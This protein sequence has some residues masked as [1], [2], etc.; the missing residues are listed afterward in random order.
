MNA[1][2]ISA[3]R[4]NIE[5]IRCIPVFCY[6]FA[7]NETLDFFACHRSRR[8]ANGGRTGRGGAL[9][10]DVRH[11]SRRRRGPRAH[12]RGS[13]LHDCRACARRSRNRRDDLSDQP[14]HPRRAARHRRIRYRQNL[15]GNPANPTVG[16][17]HVS[18]ACAGFASSFRDNSGVERMGPR[19]LQCAA[20]TAARIH[21][22]RSAAVFR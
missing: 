1:S 19:D 6:N 16:A 10:A 2:P 4:G 20:S 18:N 7:R 15:H 21:R 3:A 11:L 9:P 8:W 13:P 5:N 14:T 22:R 17:S 12:S